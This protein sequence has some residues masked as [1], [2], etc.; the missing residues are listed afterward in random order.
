MMLSFAALGLLP[1]AARFGLGRVKARRVY[2]RWTKPR[3]FDRNLVVIGAGSAGLVSAYIAAAVQARVTLVERGLMGGDCLNYGCVPSKALIRSAK[4]AHHI[5]SSAEFGVSSAEARTDFP[6]VMARIRQVIAEIAPHD[7]VERYRGLGVDVRQGSARIVDPWTVEIAGDGGTERLTTRSI[8]IAT[9][10]SPVVPPLPGLS[11]VAPLTSDTM[12]DH[13]STQDR[14]PGRIV[15]L[16]GGPI[17]CELSQSFSRLG[18][19]VTLIEMADRLLLREDAEV[20]EAVQ[21]ALRDNGVTLLTGHRALAAGRD[22]HGKWIEVVGPEGRSRIGFDEII[23]A[24]GRVARLSGLGLEELGIPASRIVETN[25]YLETIYPNIYAA[26]DV[27]GPYQLTHAGA[28]QAWFAVV[29]ALFGRFRRFRADYRVLPATTFTDPEVARVGLNEAEAAAKGIAYEVT[30]YGLDDLD[31]AIADGSATGWVKVLTV[32]GR[33]RILGATIVGDRAGDLLAEFALAM[34]HGLGLNRILSTVHSYPTL[35][36]ANKFA[37]GVWR[38]NHVNPTV[39]N[40]L[41]RYHAWA[42]G[43]G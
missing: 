5:A 10:A 42:R 11:D 34:R 9:G 37:A 14:L 19:E 16:G 22:D 2:G 1:W 6:A 20:S 33:D 12:W 13:F 29:N 39:L 36:E 40:L 17:G 38:R 3:S 43:Q 30:R 41:R 21:T 23:V 8:I 15:L 32:P 31:R 35:A 28:H 25:E 26:G 27:A 18:A 24:V 7:S 4:A